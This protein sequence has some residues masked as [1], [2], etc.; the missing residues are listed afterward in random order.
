MLPGQDRP[1]HRASRALPAPEILA[2]WN[3]RLPCGEIVVCRQYQEPA[4]GPAQRPE[5]RPE[6]RGV[7]RGHL[8]PPGRVA[9]RVPARPGAG[10]GRGPGRLLQRPAAL[11]AERVAAELGLP[12]GTVKSRLARGRTALAHQ[13][14]V[15]VAAPD[16]ESTNA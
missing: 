1:N 4:G 3:L 16:E 12:V 5:Q 14:R 15:G 10:R 9:V 7:L 6:L 8:R 11:A 2:G 13:L